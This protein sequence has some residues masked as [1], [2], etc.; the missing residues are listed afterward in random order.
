M[1]NI[2]IGFAKEN[3]WSLAVGL[4]LAAVVFAVG[5]A[6]VTDDREIVETVTGPD[7]QPGYQFSIE[8]TDEQQALRDLRDKVPCAFD[9]LSIKGNA[10]TFTGLVR[11]Q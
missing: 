10:G 1:P 9:V 5:Y 2:S 7:G 4:T 11:C 3:R 8:A 6:Y